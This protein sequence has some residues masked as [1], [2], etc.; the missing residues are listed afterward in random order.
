MHSVH[1]PELHYLLVQQKLKGSFALVHLTTLSVI[2]GVALAD[3][4]LVVAGHAQQFTLTQWLLVLLAFAVL[5]AAWSQFTMH[6]TTW[7]WIPD[8]VDAM[9][10]FG[11]GVPR[12]LLQ[13]P[14]PSDVEW[15]AGYFHNRYDDVHAG[16]VAHRK[17]R[18]PGER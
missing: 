8:L 1:K 12:T 11:I 13:S 18:Q 10:P 9:I 4:A 2:Q 5:L 7:D 16:P 15:L 14:D 6:V 17:A 3:L